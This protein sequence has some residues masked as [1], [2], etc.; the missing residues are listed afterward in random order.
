MI[1]K[2]HLLASILHHS[3]LLFGARAAL[4]SRLLGVNYHRIHPDGERKAYPFDEG[5][6]GPT[7]SGFEEHIR[8]LARN[9]R[10]LSERDLIERFATGQ[11]PEERSA[12]ITF[13][14]GYRDQYT[15]AYPIL[16]RLRVPAI[17]FIPT[18]IITSRRLGWWDVI[19][20]LIKGSRRDLVTLDGRSFRLP[21]ERKRAIR[22]FHGRMKLVPQARTADLIERLSVACD[23]PPPDAKTQDA[24]LMTWAQVRECAESGMAI[25]SHGETHAVL[26]T[27]DPLAQEAELRQSRAEIERHTGQPV[28]SLSYPVGNNAHFTRETQRIAERCGY[29]QAF[30]FGVGLNSQRG[31]D[32]FD[33]RRISGGGSNEQGLALFAA[34]ATWPA[35]FG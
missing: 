21:A 35:L 9:F 18:E 30:S 15:L 26:A 11:W 5:V 34:A 14:D 29:L 3:G 7:A 2:R 16:R 17:F 27:L 19:A 10:I 32:R 22:Y 28:Y 23:T 13:D 8:W 20:Y 33:I 12:I 24:E 31:V 4:G 6:F 1:A 25:G